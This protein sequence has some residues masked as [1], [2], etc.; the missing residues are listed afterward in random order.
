MRFAL[1]VFVLLFGLLGGAFGFHSL[2]RSHLAT[3][4]SPRLASLLIRA[5]EE[6][7]PEERFGKGDLYEGDNDTEIR[8]RAES[9][10]SDNMKAKLKNELRAQGADAN[11]VFN[12]Y[13]LLFIG[14]A[15]LVVL[16][17]AGIFY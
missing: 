15:F 9:V 12:P 5:A 14:I 13:P 8:E 16:G 3:L 17:G 6:V 2:P 10:L 4:R 7:P 1:C 11:S